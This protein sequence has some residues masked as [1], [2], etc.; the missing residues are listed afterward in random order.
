MRDVERLVEL[1]LRITYAAQY[2]PAAGGAAPGL[3]EGVVGSLCADFKA[4]FHAVR[5]A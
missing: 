5:G 4:L 2:G 1:G 3:T